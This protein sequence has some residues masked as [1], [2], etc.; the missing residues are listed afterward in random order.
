ML[1]HIFHIRAPRLAILLV[2]GMSLFLRV[3]GQNYLPDNMVVADCSTGVEAMTWGVHIDWSSAN[4]LVCNLNIPLVGDLDGDGHPDI[5]CFSLAGQLPSNY[6][7]N[8]NQMLV[9][10][11]VTKQLKAT[12]TMESPVSAFDAAAYGL[13]RTANG[14]GLIV[15]A[16]IDYKLRAY[17]I[18]SPTPN[19]PYWVSDVNYGTGTNNYAVNVS[20]AD[21]NG[22][23]HPE[24]YVKNKIFNAENGKLL[25]EAATTNTGNSFAHWTHYTHR[26]LSAPMAADICG[27]ARPELILGNEI[28]E[29]SITNTNGTAGNSL[30]LVKQ[31]APPTGVPA[32]GHSQVADF[33]LDGHP[34][35]F[36]SIR[37]TDMHQGTVY[38]YV[39]DVFNQ[40]VSNPLTIPTSF[41]GKSIPL[42]ADIDSDGALEIVIQNGSTDTYNRIQAYKYNAATQ[43]FSMMWGLHPDEDSFSNSFTAF[44]FNQD[45]LLELVICDQSTLR[46][47]N[48]SGKSHITHNDT[49]PVYVLNSFPFSETTIMQYPVIADADA[50]A[51]AEIVS[52]GSTKLNILK[53][54]GLPWAPAR[55]V[56]NQYM[57]NVTNINKDLSVPTTVFNNATPFTDPS[58]VVRRPFNNFLQ[59]ATTLDHYGRPFVPLA[60]ASATADTSSSFNNNTITYTFRICNTGSLHIT[61]PFYITYYTNTYHGTVIRTDMVSAMLMPDSCLVWQAQFPNDISTSFPNLE[62]IVVALNDNG[63]GVAQTG[64]QQEECDTTDNFF[65]FNFNQCSIPRDTVVADVCVFETY[66]DQNFD[67]PSSATETAGTYYFSRTYQVGGCDSVIVLKL[68]VHP[69]YDLHITETVP[70]GS[71][72]DHYGIFLSESVLEGRRRIDTTITSQSVFGCDSV[73]HIT[74][75][76]AVADITLYLPNA[77]TP[78]GDGLNDFFCIPELIRD[79]LADFE[80]LIYDR[81]GEMVFHSKD[82]NFNWYGGVKGKTYRNTIYQYVIHYSNLFGEKSAIKGFITVL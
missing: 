45:G 61:A 43:S 1:R 75:L 28:Y 67:I 9:F 7:N 12:I 44:D 80:I 49:V 27:D 42:I 78:N 73:T 22:D 36:I 62:R 71:N 53:S 14:K 6:G 18:T 82:K 10:D 65:S 29:A 30:T 16:C 11:G 69:Q 24:V 17:D 46:I 35:V 50:D 40:T 4:N 21:F 63:T 77:I 79:Y 60:N 39:W 8:N 66:T 52:V 64:G 33:N 55:P 2:I 19:T 47:V 26:K 57:Y 72:Y 3:S 23:G 58:G 76:V 20:F 56:W 41:S 25:A 13:V 51:A 37:T 74:I 48:G 15:V 32:D 68:R 31:T 5:L 34:D 70:L 59:Q 81:W 38:C 54:S